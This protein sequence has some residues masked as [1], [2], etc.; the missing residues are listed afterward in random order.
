MKQ[1]YQAGEVNP[2]L[3]SN[4]V[5]AILALIF[6]GAAIFSYLGFQDQK[7]NVQRKVDA[8]VEIA[9]EDQ[10]KEDEKR[11]IEQE[12]VPTREFVGPDSLGR[13]SFQYPKTW[14]VF[15]AKNSGGLETYLYPNIVPPISEQQPFATRVV[16]VDTPYESVLKTYEGLIK[17]GDLNSTPYTIN[18]FSGIRLDGK[19][20]KDR[21]GSVI[22]FQ[23]RDK[24]LTMATDSVKY[25]TDFDN[26]IMKTFSFNP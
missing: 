17:K 4:I 14:S 18:G 21:E 9:K 7:Q 12:K 11:F 20:S 10:K 25:K 22:L 13:V 6:V 19:F 16:I 3:I 2:L 8:A 26:T 24:T 5:T 1:H 15:V 23:V